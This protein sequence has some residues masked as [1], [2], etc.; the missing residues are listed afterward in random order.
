V[1][2]ITDTGVH[3]KLYVPKA[4]NFFFRDLSVMLDGIDSLTGV[5]VTSGDNVYGTSFAINDNK[6]LVNLNFNELLMQRVNKYVEAFEADYNK[7]YAYD[8]AYYFVQMLKTG[9]RESYEARLNR[10]T[11]PPVLLTV[12]INNGA[13]STIPKTV[14]VPPMS[15]PTT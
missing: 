1:K 15:I 12:K 4:A 3:Y 5:N 11:S 10:F 9:L 13:T 8:D 2:T 6:L 7:E 14:F